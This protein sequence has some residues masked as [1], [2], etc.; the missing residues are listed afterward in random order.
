MSNRFKNCIDK[1]DKTI[2]L[3]LDGVDFGS[4][5]PMPFNK[6]LIETDMKFLY[7]QLK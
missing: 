3:S 2:F 6:K 7:H 5:E 1:S 4:N